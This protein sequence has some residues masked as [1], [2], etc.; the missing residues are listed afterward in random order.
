M[1]KFVAL[2]TLLAL[3]FSFTLSAVAAEGDNEFVESITYKGAPEIVPIVDEHGNSYHGIIRDSKDA[4]ADYVE[5][6]CLVITPLAELET[7]TLI[8]EDSR[9][10]FRDV[11]NKLTDGSMTLPYK[12]AR[13]ANT[14]K[15]VIRDLFDASWLCSDHPVLVAQD[16][17]TVELC[18]DIGVS[19]S[20]NVIVMSYVNDAWEHAV[21]VVNNGDGTVT[22]VLEELCPIVF[23]VKTSEGEDPVGPSEP[24]G[25]NGSYVYWILLG[26][27]GVALVVM[28]GTALRRR[29]I[30]A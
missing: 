16:G 8:P 23:S 30:G 7:S 2:F 6:G 4:I 12:S 22:C 21:S 26:L 3:C 20:E 24:T 11:Y 9:T 13:S 19:A 10:I 18:F 1:K 5:E 29:S 25:D 15:Y 14:D 17:V 27:A 28:G